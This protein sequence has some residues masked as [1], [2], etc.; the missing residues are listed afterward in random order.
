[1]NIFEIGTICLALFGACLGFAI[2]T[3]YGTILGIAAAITG[4]LFGY[5]IGPILGLLILLPFETA[6]RVGRNL[7]SRREWIR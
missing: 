5:F 2:A 6:S 7:V 1:M 4:A 3:P